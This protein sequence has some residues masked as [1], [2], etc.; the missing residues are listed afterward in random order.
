MNDFNLK[1]IEKETGK[2][3]EV[4][5]VT[6]SD[7]IIR[8]PE[9][10]LKNPVSKYRLSKFFSADRENFVRCCERNKRRFYSRKDSS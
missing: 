4:K 9:T 5:R 1:Y 6:T 3:F 8:D 2:V 7:Y 10:G